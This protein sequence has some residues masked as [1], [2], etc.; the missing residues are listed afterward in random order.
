MAHAKDIS[1]QEFLNTGS[2]GIQELKELTDKN[3]AI[4]EM[5]EC[6]ANL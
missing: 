1:V 6:K 5:E 2:Q 4:E 3:G